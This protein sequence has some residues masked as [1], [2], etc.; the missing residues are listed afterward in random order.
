M[1][2]TDLEFKKIA[3]NYGRS[4]GKERSISDPH[5]EWG[6]LRIVLETDTVRTRSVMYPRFGLTR[7]K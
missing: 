1:N 7:R 5:C 6:R 4:L 3:E 2:S